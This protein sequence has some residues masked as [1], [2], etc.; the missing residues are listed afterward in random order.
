[1]TSNWSRG[2]AWLGSLALLLGASP[3]LAQDAP[4]KEPT[5]QEL[6]ERIQKLEEQAAAKAPAKEE[7]PAAKEGS[8]DPLAFE[9][10]GSMKLKLS[11]HLRWRGEYRGRPYTA[12]TK[13]GEQTDF[14]WQRARITF[15]LGMTKHF[16]ARVSVNDSRLWGD[17]GAQGDALAPTLG[18]G[19]TASTYVSEAWAQASNLLDQPLSLR[20]GRMKV[21]N[22]GDQRLV[23][24]LVWHNNPRFADG[25]L[26]IFSPKNW[27][28]AA[29]SFATGEGQFDTS[30]STPDVNDDDFFSGIYASNR[31]FEHHELDAFLYWRW[32]GG[33]QATDSNGNAGVQSDYTLG[34]RVKGDVGS[35]GYTF[36]GAF[37]FGDMV[38]DPIAA[39]CYA[40]ELRYTMKLGEDGSKFKVSVEHSLASGDGDPTD[41]RHE[42]FHPLLPFAHFYNGH[43][44]LILWRNM[45]TVN[46]KLGYW[47]NKNLSFH[48]DSHAF[49]LHKSTDRWYGI[50]TSQ[51]GPG[52]GQD[53][54]HVGTEFDLYAK[55]TVFDGHLSFWGGYSHFLPGEVVADIARGTGNRSKSQDW[56]FLM[57]TVKF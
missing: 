38:G 57:G 41:S 48:L 20:V 46:L 56:L 36:M 23:S 44:D 2:V 40:M 24:H 37:Q 30:D 7:A 8:E 32:M 6:L 52:M 26:G 55:W 13:V 16:S 43:Q 11:G 19:V 29:F 9:L 18:G 45:Y 31:T 35:F 25:A 22:L 47:L 27:W 34:A 54:L 17:R 1:M 53:T 42:T 39:Y 28:I 10:P 5:T 21:P 14:V 12:P 4:A 49:W 51:P 33:S 50:G 15:D 3:A